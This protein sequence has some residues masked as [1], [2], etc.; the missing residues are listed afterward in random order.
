MDM[1]PPARLLIGHLCHVTLV[2]CV[3]EHCYLVQELMHSD[4]HKAL[5]DPEQ[6]PMLQWRKQ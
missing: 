1:G 4:L 5:N 3:Q 6:A 2:L